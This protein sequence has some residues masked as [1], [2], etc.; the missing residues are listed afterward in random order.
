MNMGDYFHVKIADIDGF[1]NNTCCDHL[2]VN[3]KLTDWYCE[4]YNRSLGAGDKGA[5]IGFQLCQFYNRDG[6]CWAK[7]AAELSNK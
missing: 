2:M 1:N 7:R 5:L 3:T 6:F 4:S